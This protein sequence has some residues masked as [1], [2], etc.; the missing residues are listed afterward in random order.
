[1]LPLEFVFRYAGIEGCGFTRFQ[2]FDHA[3]DAAE[4]QGLLDGSP[5][6]LSDKHSTFTL[7][8]RDEDRLSVGVHLRDGLID[9]LPHRGSRDGCH[10]DLLLTKTSTLQ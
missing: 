3:R 4:V 8:V 1:M 10:D 7:A 6:V 2:R 9:V 5:F